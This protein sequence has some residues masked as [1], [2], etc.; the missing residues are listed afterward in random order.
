MNVIVN[1]QAWTDEHIDLILSNPNINSYKTTNIYT[2]EKIFN[3]IK[4][5]NKI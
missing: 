3:K 1:G 2:L 4:K 5:Y